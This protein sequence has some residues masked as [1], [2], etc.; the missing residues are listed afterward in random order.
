LAKNLNAQNQGRESLVV[1][2]YL[3]PQGVRPV[4]MLS[5]IKKTLG[6][7]RPGLMKISRPRTPDSKALVGLLGVLAVLCAYRFYDYWTTGFFVSDEYGYFFDAAHGAVYSDRWFFGWVNI[8][9]FKVLGITNVDAFSYLLPF[10]LFF[11]TAITLFVFYKLL[12][13]LG[14]DQVVI[15]LSLVSSFFLVSFVLLSLGFLTEPVGLCMAMLGIYCLGRFL[16][17]NSAVGWVAFPLLAG[18]FFGFAAG[19]RE[20]YN[21]FLVAGGLVV[22]L[23]AYSRRNEAVRTRRLGT[24]PLLGTSVLV[25]VIPSLFFIVVPTHAYSQQIA[26]I[27][28][29]LLQTIITNPKTSGGGVTTTTPNGGPPAV[30]FYRAFI[31][32][33]TILIFLGGIILGWGPICF[34]I[35][36]AGFL[37]LLRKS[38]WRR[39]VTAR[40]VFFSSVVA[41]GSYFIVS[42]I[43]A[44]DP[45]YFSFQN[46]STVIRFS[47]TALPAYFLMAPFFLSLVAKN[48]R[49]MAGLVAVFLIFVAVALPVYQV[50]AVS[51]FGQ[52]N[53]NPFSLSY[54]T[55]AADV[56]NYFA[57]G[58][59]TAPYNLV[60]LPY[61]WAFTP[62]VQDLKGVSAY[63]LVANGQA[64][65]MNYT[66]FVSLHWGSFYVSST[67]TTGRGT[68]LPNY[69]SDLIQQNATVILPYSLVGSQIVLS[70]PGFVLLHVY[71]SWK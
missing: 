71:V 21:A 4:Q 70:E 18:C 8:F 58:K 61:G 39:D 16:K 25:F 54:H 65:P 33:N 14:F 2:E 29:Q 59:A 49:R 20:P 40:F 17:S 55:P 31:G 64:P 30:P 60:G 56:R 46:Y 1:R 10:Y 44:P 62:G 15:A 45:Y 27:G 57:S 50:Y 32:T 9:L 63:T 52:T 26:P 66:T 28:N 38:F 36:L 42:F 43:Y 7:A 13:L 67:D 69:L 3:S 41:L 23:I 22:L 51:N 48:R 19:T 47:D 11:W 68:D 37:I 34:V 24:K 12:N 35:A 53:G 6:I 5:G